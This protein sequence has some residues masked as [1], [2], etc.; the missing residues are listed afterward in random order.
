MAANYR[1]P[2]LYRG[3]IDYRGRRLKPPTATVRRLRFPVTPRMNQQRIEKGRDYRHL[4]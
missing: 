1:E 4:R 2:V 3:A